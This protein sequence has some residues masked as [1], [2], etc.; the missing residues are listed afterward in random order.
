MVAEDLLIAFSAIQPPLVRYAASWPF[1]VAH[2][3]NLLF[4]HP[5]V[6]YWRRMLPNRA[7]CQYPATHANAIFPRV[8][9]KHPCKFLESLCVLLIKVD[10]ESPALV[11][12]DHFLRHFINSSVYLGVGKFISVLGPPYFPHINKVAFSVFVLDLCSESFQRAY[13]SFHAPLNSTIIILMLGQP[14]FVVSHDLLC[15]VSDGQ[16]SSIEWEICHACNIT[17]NFCRV[18]VFYIS[19]VA[20]LHAQ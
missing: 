20:T 17:R 15:S 3:V 2:L 1:R 19:E 8:V 13:C 18:A 10:Y 4:A 6:V 16:S 7:V 9:L 12:S 11:S 14:R 5:V